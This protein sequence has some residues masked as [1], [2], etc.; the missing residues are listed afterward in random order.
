MYKT[1]PKV[2]EFV[3][4]KL[5]FLPGKRKTKH[6]QLNYKQTI[7]VR[8]E[9]SMKQHLL[10]GALTKKSKFTKPFTFHFYCYLPLFYHDYYHYFY[11]VQISG[12]V[13]KIIR[14]KNSLP[15]KKNYY[16]VQWNSSGKL[17]FKAVGRNDSSK[18]SKK[19]SL[20]Y[21]FSSICFPPIVSICSF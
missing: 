19:K 9:I 5:P 7:F 2:L 13:D 18:H 1:K 10:V 15:K 6:T 14:T 11:V 8:N 21:Y 12:F 4:L 3:K 20:F 16:I 17:P